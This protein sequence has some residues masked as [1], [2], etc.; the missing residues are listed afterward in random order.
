ME[1]INISQLKEDL[2]NSDS[3]YFYKEIKRVVNGTKKVNSMNITR[4]KVKLIVKTDVKGDTYLTD[5]SNEIK[6]VLTDNSI[7]YK[8]QRNSYVIKKSGAMI[9][10]V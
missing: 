9:F 4:E 7:I 8:S 1:V 10:I 6:C 5:Q 3:L 2:E